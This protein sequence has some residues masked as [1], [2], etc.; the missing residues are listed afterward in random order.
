MSKIKLATHCNV[1]KYQSV[2]DTAAITIFLLI[3]GVLNYVSSRHQIKLDFAARLPR[4][5]F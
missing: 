2:E 4:L 1:N 5:M 3:K